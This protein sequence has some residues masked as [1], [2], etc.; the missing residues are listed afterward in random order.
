FLEHAIIHALIEIDNKDVASLN[1]TV[2]SSVTRRAALIA[3]DQMNSGKLD[4]NDV[5]PLLST[6]DRA[7]QQTAWQ[8]ALKH[9]DWL[10]DVTGL[11]RKELQAVPSAER[12]EQLRELLITA[13]Q[14]LAVEVFVAETLADKA[15]S[16]AGRLL[17]LEV[18][19]AAD[20]SKPP[21]SLVA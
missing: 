20:G 17:L 13:C 4:R 21:P 11:I 18:V 19:A 8:I 3:L 6:D 12:R 14:S 1:L 9:P 15:T 10:G 5:V 2:K 7:L 16:E